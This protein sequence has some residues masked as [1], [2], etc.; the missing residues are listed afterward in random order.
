ML[1]FFRFAFVLHCCVVLDCIALHRCIF[2]FPL[3]LS[4]AYPGSPLSVLLCRSCSTATSSSATRWPPSRRSCSSRRSSTRCEHFVCFVYS[5]TTPMCSL[6]VIPCALTSLSPFS[7]AFS[8]FSLS[9]SSFSPSPSISVLLRLNRR[10][11]PSDAQYQSLRSEFAAFE[12]SAAAFQ[13]SFKEEIAP[14]IA[15]PPALSGKP[16]RSL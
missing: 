12:K 2:F 9:I 15:K 4:P 7:F 14:W 5:T 10:Q 13:T 11:A 8:L 3:P 16:L 1:T 6:I